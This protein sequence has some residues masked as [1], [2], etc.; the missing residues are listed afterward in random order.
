MRQ[1]M[2]GIA[3]LCAITLSAGSLISLRAAPAQGPCAEIAAACQRA[4]FVQGGVN[5]GI[6]LQ[7]NCIQPIMQATAQQQK[8]VKPLPQ[9]DQELV[10]ACKARNPG[11]G[12]PQLAQ[13]E[14]SDQAAPIP[15]VQNLAPPLRPANGKRPNILFILTDDL[16]WNLVQAVV[17]HAPVSGLPLPTPG[18]RLVDNGPGWLTGGPW[19]PEGGLAAAGGMLVATFLLVRYQPHEPAGQVR[20]GSDPS[21]RRK[22]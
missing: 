7:V 6:G 1:R 10:A 18:Y 13:S 3:A 2:C 9:V 14:T 17:L 4:G 19:G 8:S 21:G 5:K 20:I 16:A 22:T 15:V 12:R 11:F